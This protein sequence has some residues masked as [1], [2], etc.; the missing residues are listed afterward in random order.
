M[1]ILNKI[2]QFYQNVFISILPSSTQTFVYV[3]IEKNKKSNVIHKE[4]F[5]TSSSNKALEEYVNRY[6]QITPLFYVAVFCNVKE[7][8]AISSCSHNEL[9]KFTDISTSITICSDNRWSAFASI[10][11]VDDVNSTYKAFGLDYLISPF[12]II[13]TFFHEK[14]DSGIAIYA[15]ILEDCIY[16]SIYKESK[17][18]YA[19]RGDFDDIE[20]QNSHEDEDGDKS[21]TS[22]DFDLETMDFDDEFHLDDIE[23]I[24]D[25]D[26]LDD[27]SNIEDLDSADDLDEFEQNETPETSVDLDSD[28]SSAKDSLAN[29]DLNFKRFLII[30]DSLKSFYSNPNYDSQFIEQ[31]YTADAIHC[32][33]EFKSYLEDEL[34]LTVY[35]RTID[36]NSTMV[37]MTRQEVRDAS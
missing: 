23:M 22:M 19:H 21:T 2:K 34:F 11:E 24:D 28:P 20:E 27:L 36:I 17:L 26:N 8:G 9:E 13:E 4:S 25:F 16:T 7:Q 29:L 32:S 12:S 35:S 33:D 18:L 14:I 30:Q 37:D 31:I 5:N 6:T 15:L 1:K 10:K 3:S